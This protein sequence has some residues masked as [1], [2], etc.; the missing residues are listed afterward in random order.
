MP[1]E[2][3]AQHNTVLSAKMEIRLKRDACF[4]PYQNIKKY[5]IS[6]EGERERDNQ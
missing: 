4:A 5:T 2:T 6:S 1:P 3:R